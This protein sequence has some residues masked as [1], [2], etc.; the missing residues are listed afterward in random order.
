MKNLETNKASI[1]KEALLKRKNLSA[2]ERMDK[3]QAI[4]LSLVETD[5]YINSDNILVYAAYNN[6]VDTDL[7]VLRSI[8]SGKKVYMPKVSGEDMDFYRVF[9]LDELASG[10]FGIREPYDIEHLKYEGD[11]SS[12]CILPLASFDIE[13]NRIGYGKGYYD[14]YLARVKV[15]HTAG[16]AFECQ[17]SDQIIEINVFD[18]KLDMVITEEE[19]YNFK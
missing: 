9:S 19:I 1:R 17:K 12:I 4:V 6:E 13:G 18:H 14:R 10:S 2:E 16:I 3:S 8:M 7:L 11:D 15:K 5:E